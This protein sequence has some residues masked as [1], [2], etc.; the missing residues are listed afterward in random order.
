M[1]DVVKYFYTDV[2]TYDH[3]CHREYVV[4]YMRSDKLVGHY[5]RCCVTISSVYSFDMWCITVVYHHHLRPVSP[6]LLGLGL[7]HFQLACSVLC[8]PLRC[9]RPITL[10]DILA[11]FVPTLLTIISVVTHSF[12]TKI[13]NYLSFHSI[14]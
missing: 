10:S 3:I 6:T 2:D 14:H 1:L 4:L 13:C 7:F 5:H 8:I 9:G 11:L 12:I